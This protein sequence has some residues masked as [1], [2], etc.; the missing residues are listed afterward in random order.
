MMGGAKAQYDRVKALS[1]T[2]FH[3]DLRSLDIPVMVM[4]GLDDQIAPY[5]ATGER[6][7]KLLKHGVLKTYP[8]LPHGMPTTHAEIINADLLAFIQS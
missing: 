1:E 7:I 6:A 4:H 3:E 8:G 2:D 5:A